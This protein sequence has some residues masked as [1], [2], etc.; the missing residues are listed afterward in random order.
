M[1]D[2][3]NGLLFRLSPVEV[4]FTH[5]KNRK[6]VRNKKH[7]N[8]IA[9]TERIKDLKNEW[10]DKEVRKEKMMQLIMHVIW[11]YN[12]NFLNFI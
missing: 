2:I 11:D 6:P 10:I 3:S 4:Y 9:C 5:S 1:S 7:K 12:A 8:S